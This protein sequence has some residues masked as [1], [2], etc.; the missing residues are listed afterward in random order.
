MNQ[1]TSLIQT[2]C[3]EDYLVRIPKENI[4]IIYLTEIE[5][6]LFSLKRKKRASLKLEEE[7]INNTYSFLDEEKALVS[8]E[9][10]LQRKIPRVGR[11]DLSFLELAKKAEYKIAEQIFVSEVP[12]F[13]VYSEDYSNFEIQIEHDRYNNNLIINFP[14]YIHEIIKKHLKKAIKINDKDILKQNSVCKLKSKFYGIIPNEA[15]ETIEKA[16][17]YFNR[18]YIITE[19]QNYDGSVEIVKDPLIIGILNDKGFLLD[20]FNCTPLETYAKNFFIYNKSGG[21]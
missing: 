16:K 15:R 10:E 19:A 13:A 11:I 1:E 18:T 21:N 9:L 2:R 7:L 4:S 5:Q 20:E 17:D 8:L 6:N 12:I 14:S 3:L